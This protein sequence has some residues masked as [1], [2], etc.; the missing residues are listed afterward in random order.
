MH[1]RVSKSLGVAVPLLLCVQVAVA[2]IRETPHSLVNTG[3]VGVKV[4]E[5][6]V[7]IYC[8]TPV[9]GTNGRIPEHPPYW[10]ASI[11]KDF[12]FTIYDDIG[13]LGFGKPSVGSQSIACLSCHDAN[14]ALS[15]SKTSADHPFGVPYRGAIKQR[16]RLAGGPSEPDRP[17]SPPHRHAQ[18]LVALEDF[19]DVSRG[20]IEDRTVWWVSTAGVTA[21]RSRNDLPLYSRIDDASGEELPH[22]ECSSCHDPHS[23]NELFLRVRNDGSALC[24][25]CHNK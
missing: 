24:L 23:P 13:R 11:G 22:I 19:R 17:D 1:G 9:I 14:Q 25:T 4:D 7:C 20:V 8:H 16:P 15:V 21:R 6:E 12:T 2:D 3:A 10:Q 18:K 5:R